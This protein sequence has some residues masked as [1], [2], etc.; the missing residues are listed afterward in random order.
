[1][2]K[3]FYTSLMIAGALFLGLTSC[4]KDGNKATLVVH[5]TD[6][7]ANYEEVLIDVQGIQIHS[8]LNEAEGTWT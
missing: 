8:S 2:K 4:T 1:M 5:L 3:K 6:A 7:P